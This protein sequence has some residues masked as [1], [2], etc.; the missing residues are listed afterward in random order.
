MKIDGYRNAKEST[1][2]CMPKKGA[3]S[4]SIAKKMT[5]MM[6]DNE[7]FLDGMLLKYVF[8]RRRKYCRKNAHD[9]HDILKAIDCS[10]GVSSCKD[11]ELLQ[12]AETL[13]FSGDNKNF[14]CPFLLV[15]LPNA[16]P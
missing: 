2:N 16:I 7:E 11:L 8:F 12:N 15:D 1:I 6:F 3:S 10:G 5:R 4:E 9:A 14:L 13:A